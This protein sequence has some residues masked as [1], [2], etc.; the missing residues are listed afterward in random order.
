MKYTSEISIFLTMRFTE[1]IMSHLK[2]QNWDF[3]ITY[4]LAGSLIASY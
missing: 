1:A 4:F 3:F 2:V